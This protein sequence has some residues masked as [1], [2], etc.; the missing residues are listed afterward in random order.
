MY[1]NRMKAMI[2]MIKILKNHNI[3]CIEI[4]EYEYCKNLLNPEEP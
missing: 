2:Q 1:W 4:K 3:R